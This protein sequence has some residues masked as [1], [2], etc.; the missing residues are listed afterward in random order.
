[1]KKRNQN[2]KKGQPESDDEMRSDYGPEFFKGGER[3]KYY[4]RAMRSK[5]IIALAPDVASVFKDSD[6]VNEALRMLLDVSRRATGTEARPR[7]RRNKS[8]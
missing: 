2:P 1:M 5:Q 4:E 8:A 3:G 7:S 6:Q